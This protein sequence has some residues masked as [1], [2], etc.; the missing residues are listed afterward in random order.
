[1][2]RL[3]VH[4]REGFLRDKKTV[5][6]PQCNSEDSYFTFPIDICLNCGYEFGDLN[7]L[8]DEE[9]ARRGFHFTGEIRESY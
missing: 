8:I 7:Q 3:E 5:T 6:C 4:K 9:G 2:I 1:M